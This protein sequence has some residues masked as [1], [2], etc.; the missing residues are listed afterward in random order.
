MA[1]SKADKKSRIFSFSKE[2]RKLNS[3]QK[4][5]FGS[6]LIVISFVLLI[7]FTS[8]FFT[9][10]SDQST[11]IQFTNNDVNPENWMSKV[12]AFLADLFLH[13]GF[14]V[15]SYIICFLTF[16]S[17]LFVLLDLNKLKL[18]RHWFWGILIMIWVSLLFGLINLESGKY[19]GIIGFE[20]NIFLNRYIG[21]IGTS[22]LL[23]LSAIFLFY[24]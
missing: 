15:S 11:L 24:F 10:A 22:F 13:K 1:K 12:G 2:K 23:L 17:G 21:N 18:N 5:F 3:S 8:Y 6:T 16:I 20:S 19:S 9:G 14:G 7:S 4:L